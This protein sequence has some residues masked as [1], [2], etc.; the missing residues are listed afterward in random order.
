[1]EQTRT[2]ARTLA[3]LGYSISND[4]ASGLA[5]LEAIVDIAEARLEAGV[6]AEGYGALCE[7]IERT[8]IRSAAPRFSRWLVDILRVLASSSC[9]DEER[10]REAIGTLVGVSRSISPG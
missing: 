4:P 9:P 6:D 3:A 7:Q 10:R 5:D 1:M 8:W 2:R